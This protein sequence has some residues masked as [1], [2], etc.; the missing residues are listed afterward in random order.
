MLILRQT[1]NGPVTWEGGCRIH[2]LHLCKGGKNTPDECPENDTKQSDGKVPVMQE[3]QKMQSTS[4]LKL[5]PG[6]LWTKVVAPDRVQ[7]MD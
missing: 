5:L 4:S 6:P 3:L 1:E 2:R 7:S